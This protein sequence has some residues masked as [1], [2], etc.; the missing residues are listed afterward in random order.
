ML[1][2]SRSARIPIALA[3]VAL[4]A[5]V[6]GLAEV[7]D[8]QELQVRELPGRAV[9]AHVLPADLDRRRPDDGLHGAGGHARLRRPGREP[10]HREAGRPRALPR[11]EGTEHGGHDHRERR[12]RPVAIRPSDWATA[13]GF[14]VQGAPAATSC[15]CY[16]IAGLAPGAHTVRMYDVILTPGEKPFRARM[17]VHLNVT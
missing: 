1:P 12:R 9:G 3:A 11:P 14:R 16:A 15:Y 5:V 7:G 2:I 8:P 4:G 17:T 13:R 6:G 10:V